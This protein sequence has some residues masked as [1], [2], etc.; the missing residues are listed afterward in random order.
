METKR[1]GII[2]Y[3]R[4]GKFWEKFFTDKGF[5]VR[6]SDIGMDPDNEDVAMW[7]DVVIIAVTLMETTKVIESFL[8]ILRG[9]QLIIDLASTKADSTDMMLASKSEVLGLHPF[10]APPVK[11]GTFKGQTMFVYRARLS[12]WTEWVDAFLAATKA[13]I[14]LIE[15]EAHDRERTVDQVLDHLCTLLKASVMRRMELNASLLFKT[16]SPVYKLTLAQMA[17]M[18]AQS[19]SLYGALPMT[20]RFVS[21]TLEIFQEELDEFRS[22]VSRGDI[23][24]YSAVFDANR[25]YIGADTV[26]E[27]FEF[28]EQVIGL[29]GDL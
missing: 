20:N 12:A 10:C 9:D 22:Q 18:F 4:Y 28:S 6:V 2:G 7:A 5:Q 23:E 25:K 29:T 26:D 27:L 16:A 11:R 19:A 3:G 21:R 15:P 1:I 17:R 24:A 8:N 14:Q 13:Q